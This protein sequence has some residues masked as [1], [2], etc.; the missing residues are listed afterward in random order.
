[1]RLFLLYTFRLRLFNAEEFPVF[2]I[3]HSFQ[4]IAWLALEGFADKIKGAETHTAGLVG[5]EDA[6]IVLN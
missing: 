4:D 2:F 3:S 5:A 6:E 1:M